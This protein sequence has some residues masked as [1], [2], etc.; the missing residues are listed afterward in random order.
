MLKFL[1]ISNYALIDSAQIDFEKGFSVITGE[2]GAG[3]SIMLGALSLIMGQRSDSSSM[4][5]KSRKCIVEGHFYIADYNLKS[6]F[7]QEDLDYD[8]ETVIRRELLPSGKSRAFVNDTPVTLNSLK[9]LTGSLIDIHS[10]HQNLLLGDDSFQLSV[11]D[12][13]AASFDLLKQYRNKYD[14]LSNLEKE[15][16]KVIDLNEKMAADKDYIE[17]QLSQLSGAKLKEGEEQELEQEL[18][19]LTHAEEVKSAFATSHHLLNNSEF[20]IVDGFYK[21]KTEIEGVVEY[22]KNGSDLLNRLESLDIELHDVARE[23]EELGDNIEFDAERIRVVQ[24]R[25]DLIYSLQQKHKVSTAAELIKIEDEYRNRIEK[26]ES[27]DDELNKLSQAIKSQRLETEKTA[28]ELT[29]MRKAVFK[30]IENRITSMLYELGMPNAR[31]SVFYKK[32]ELTWNGADEIQFLF[33]ANKSGELSDIPKVVSGGEM[34]R[35]MLCIKSLLSSAK[36]LPTIIFDEIDT[37]VSGEIADKMGRIMQG[38]GEDI[39]VISITHLPQ[40]AGKGDF[41]YKVYKTDIND[42]TVSEIELLS[43]DDRVVEIAS[44]LSGSEL[45]N[46]ALSNAKALMKR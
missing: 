20:P 5:D 29:I 6:L 33:N 14:K 38:M 16:S 26:L 10:Q 40:I 12:T 39:Q 23:I 37:G 46:A 24:D 45:S 41:H 32:T 9:V 18:K 28:G 36:G 17:F 19:Q 43:N 7:Y 30:D 22:I 25:L 35:L 21:V 2:T 1:S 27:F 13:V 4:N 11:V 34:S 31:F 42:K 44:M 8:D 15:K 3:K